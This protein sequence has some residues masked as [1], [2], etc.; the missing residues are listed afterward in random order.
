MLIKSEIFVI[1]ERSG[2][3]KTANDEKWKTTEVQLAHVTSPYRA[4]NVSKL[5]KRVNVLSERKNSVW[6][7]IPQFELG[8][9]L[10][11]AFSFF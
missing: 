11:N 10:D 8:K 4:A 9:C 7:L 1:R 2:N 5:V 3:R 6:S